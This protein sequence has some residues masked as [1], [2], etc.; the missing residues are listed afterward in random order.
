MKFTFSILLLVLFSFASKAQDIDCDSLALVH[1]ESPGCIEDMDAF[2]LGVEIA[3]K[4]EGLA[5][6]SLGDPGHVDNC[7]FMS[8]ENYGVKL[9]LTG[10]IVM[11]SQVDENAGF[12]AIMIP[13]IKDSLGE[14]YDLLGK[15][16]SNWIDLNE[17]EFMYG[18]ITPFK[19]LIESDSTVRVTLNPELKKESVFQTFEGIKFSDLKGEWHE[20]DDFYN[21]VILARHDNEKL[22]L[23]M[24]FEKY[25]NPGGICQA[26]DVYVIPVSIK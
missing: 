23:R 9:V 2:C 14:K 7:T 24:N 26:T 15:L 16:D 18:I 5:I 12:N 17:H 21:G 6:R 25:S 4:L 19:F 10:D 11:Q 13:R 20:S 8:F 1:C 3:L 22:Y